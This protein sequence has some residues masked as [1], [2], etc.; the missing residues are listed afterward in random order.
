MRKR[1]AQ[2]LGGQGW[3]R[4]MLMRGPVPVHAG[5]AS[6]GASWCGSGPRTVLGNGASVPAFTTPPCITARK[7][8]RSS[9]TRDVGEHVAVDDQHV[10]ELA[11]LERAE[12]VVRGP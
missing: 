8:E 12:L 5:G 6:T 3:G 9:S 2:G 7:R 11:G 10:G 1:V 4:V